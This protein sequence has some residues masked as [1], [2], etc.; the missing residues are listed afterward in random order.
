MAEKRGTNPM[1]EATNKNPLSDQEAQEMVYLYRVIRAGNERPGEVERC[2][3]LLE[4]FEATKK[5]SG[6]Q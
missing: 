6:K 1:S 5:G 4:R 2:R 3:E